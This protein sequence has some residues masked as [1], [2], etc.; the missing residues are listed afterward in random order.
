M[1]RRE[2]ESEL[3]G[4]LSRLK[5]AVSLAKRAVG[6]AAAMLALQYVN[7]LFDRM[8]VTATRTGLESDMELLEEAQSIALECIEYIESKFSK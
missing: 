5:N 8:K 1:S 4:D 3:L 2:S 7:S 6:Q